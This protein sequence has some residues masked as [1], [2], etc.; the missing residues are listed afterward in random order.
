[1]WACVCVR[2][3]LCLY[4]PCACVCVCAS[5]CMRA[6]VR[7][8]DRARP[9]V[10]V[11]LCVVCV[12]SVCV[13]VC[14]LV[15]T[16]SALS[17]VCWLLLCDA[18]CFAALAAAAAGVAALVAAAAGVAALAAAVAVAASP[19]AVSA[20]VAQP[21]RETQKECCAT[22]CQFDVAT[23][24]PLGPHAPM[25]SPLGPNPP[26]PQ[27]TVPKSQGCGRDDTTTCARRHVNVLFSRRPHPA[28]P[29]C[30]RR[31]DL[32]KGEG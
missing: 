7:V 24:G 14:V 12:W 18:A 9:R 2:L 27:V 19:R 23:W 17:V 5:V 30:L 13:F 29:I 16:L 11:S 25:R 6:F 20:R 21:E 8:C 32:M 15:H 4:V 1:M 10:C 22:R 3:I 31:G 28:T 26:S